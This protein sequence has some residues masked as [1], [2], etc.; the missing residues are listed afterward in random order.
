MKWE[1]IGTTLDAKPIANRCFCCNSRLISQPS[2]SNGFLDSISFKTKKVQWNNISSSS[3]PYLDNTSIILSTNLSENLLSL[4]PVMYAISVSFWM[5]Q[6]ISLHF[7]NNHQSAIF[8]FLR[9]WLFFTV[10]GPEYDLL[11]S[12]L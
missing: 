6:V 9:I 12:A 4:R 10:G 7:S 1:V 8:G 5:N 11:S 2:V 3:G